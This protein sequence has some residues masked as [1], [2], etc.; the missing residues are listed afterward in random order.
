MKLLKGATYYCKPQKVF[1]SQKGPHKAQKAH[2]AQKELG[3]ERP[4][5]LFVLYVPYVPYV[6]SFC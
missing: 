6:A 2:K 4:F 3:C 5:S 1:S